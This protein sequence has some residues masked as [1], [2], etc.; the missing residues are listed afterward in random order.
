M[1]Y[2]MTD[3]VTGNE[4]EFD[5]KFPTDKARDVIVS[6]RPANGRKPPL[7]SV[8]DT[9]TP[10]PIPGVEGV[11]DRLSKNTLTTKDVV[12]GV[13]PMV[14]PAVEGGA[15]A[16]AG[17][18]GARAGGWPGALA[19]AG[20]GY[21]TA[22]GA[23]DAIEQ[24]VGLQPS[25]SFVG[26]FGEKAKDF[27][28]GASM[29]AGGQVGGKVIEKW[30]PVASRFGKALMGK[31]TGTGTGAIDEAVAAG[32]TAAAGTEDAFT[33]AMRGEISGAEIV[34]SA[35]AALHE[36][37]N[38]RMVEYQAGLKQLE[39]KKSI[40]ISPIRRKMDEL[41]E[42]YGFK[43][44]TD[45]TTGETFI[46]TS[47]TALNKGGNKDVLEIV[48]KIKDWGKQRGDRTP[49]GL[50]ILKRQLD[51][52]YSESN[53]RGTQQLVASLRAEVSGVIKKNVPEYAGMTKGYAEATNLIKDF[54]A[55][56]MLR[57]EG[58]SGRVTADKTLRRLMSAMKDDN[59]IRL[60]LLKVL[61]SKGN[62]DDL[63]GQ[64]AGHVM[65]QPFPRG[66]AGETPFLIGE[67]AMA[68]KLLNPQWWPILAMSSPRV[69]GEFLRVIGKASAKT[70]G[71]SGAIGKALGYGTGYGTSRVFNPRD[72]VPPARQGEEERR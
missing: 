13:V 5:D 15:A 68:Y 72:T 2:T 25:P 38:Q 30:L 44:A 62:V 27:L 49:L 71:T 28:T 63:A 9:P 10:G 23:L 18:A 7:A 20:G 21:T 64:V 51:D 31:L 19:G 22:K 29:E 57:K 60:D 54:E 36:V 37:K 61:G 46:D 65:S 42:R 67:V 59:S 39:G 16:L 11:M 32:K 1:P 8:K 34:D 66:L 24:S 48:E 56:L 53:S 6:K 40:D 35:K 47:R 41:L 52:F 43:Y 3:E 55:G 70:A 69:A 45:P 50:D 12:A 14:R 17:A 33:K 58:M 4:F 26:N